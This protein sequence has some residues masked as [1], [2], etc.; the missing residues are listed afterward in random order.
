[1]YSVYLV[2]NLVSKKRYVGIT[3]DSIKARFTRH[4]TQGHY[5][6]SSIKKHGR[7][8]FSLELITI[9]SSKQTAAKYEILLIKKFNTKFPNGYNFSDGGQCPTHTLEVRRK[10]SESKKG[11]KFSP[12]HTESIRRANKINGAKRKGIKRPEYS[13]EW[14]QNMSK[15]KT[16]IKLSDRHRQNISSA[17]KSSVKFKNKKHNDTFKTNNPSKNPVLKEI[18]ARKKWKPVY[19]VELKTCFLSLKAA[20]ESLGIKGR[21]LAT[22][23]FRGSKVNNYKF[24]YIYK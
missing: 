7:E 13:L 20:S 24:Y 12:K 22:A 9:T 8:Q 23:M 11:V 5:L 6:T 19:C 3:S 17:L 2:T 18:I 1:M 15:G 16:G 21:Q 4:C 10:I 14:K